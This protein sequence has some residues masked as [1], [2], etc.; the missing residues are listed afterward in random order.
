MCW[1]RN[2][3]WIQSL[4]LTWWPFFTILP[5]FWDQNSADAI[6]ILGVLNIISLISL[7]LY[8]LFYTA[9]MMRILVS[10]GSVHSSG[11]DKTLKIFIFKAVAHNFI[12]IIG[13]CL[14]VFL[15][16]L[17]IFL[18]DILIMTSLHV[19]FNWKLSSFRSLGL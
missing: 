5:F 7:A 14:Y 17:G 12:S 18:Q 19:L 4:Y 3:I 9:L 15:F 11:T 1:K 6:E 16:P 13:D 8:D 10:R 2:L